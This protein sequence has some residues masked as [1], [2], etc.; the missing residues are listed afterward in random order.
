MSF[1]KNFKHCV[2]V[3]G[4]YFGVTGVS[5]TGAGVMGVSVI[6]NLGSIILGKNHTK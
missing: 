4:N 6:G 2:G 5:V 3:M 1:V